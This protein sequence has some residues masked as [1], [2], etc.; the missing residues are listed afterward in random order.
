MTE[1]LRARHIEVGEK[2]EA[3][4]LAM[5]QKHD[6]DESDDSVMMIA[7]VVRNLLQEEE[8]DVVNLLHVLKNDQC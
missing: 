5:M 3:C 1:I 6:N 2:L 7:Y 4:R 8:H